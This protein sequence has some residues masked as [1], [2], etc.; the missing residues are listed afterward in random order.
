MS[1]QKQVSREQGIALVVAFLFVLGGLCGLAAWLRSRP[2]VA[3][4][5]VEM[6]PVREEVVASP[7]EE[8]PHPAGGP[9]TDEQARRQELLE[10][11]KWSAQHQR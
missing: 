4:P 3:P 2:S 5:A 9:I 8:A 1:L 7:R 11:M 6:A 10:S